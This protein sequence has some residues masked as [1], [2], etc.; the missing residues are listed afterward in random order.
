MKHNSNVV[1]TFLDKV[2]NVLKIKYPVLWKCV[3]FSDDAGSQYKKYKALSNLYHHKSDS[4][5]KAE[6]DFFATTL[7]KSPCDGIGGTAR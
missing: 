7:G 6:W 2:L 4:G 5:F 3:Y 1:H